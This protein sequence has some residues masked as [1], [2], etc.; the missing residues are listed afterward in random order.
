MRRFGF[1]KLSRQVWT[2]TTEFSES[3]SSSGFS[4]A[5][6]T[7][8]T[9]PWVKKSVG[10]RILRDSGFLRSQRSQETLLSG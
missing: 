9:F 1:K 3:A 10:E 4:E 5:I 6:W 8:S 7:D 2:P